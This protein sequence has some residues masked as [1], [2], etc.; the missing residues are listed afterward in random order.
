MAAD[1]L[2]R[3]KKGS[4]IFWNSARMGRAADV[5]EPTSRPTAIS[6]SNSETQNGQLAPFEVSLLR[7]RWT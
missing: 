4:V 6:V 2:Q 3:F 1:P 7:Q 5:P